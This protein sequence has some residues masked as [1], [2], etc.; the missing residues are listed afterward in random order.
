M[1]KIVSYRR[2]RHTQYTRQAIIVVD[3]IDSRE[4]AKELIGKEVSIK[5]SKAEIH[6]KITRLHGNKGRAV[7]LFEKGIP[8]QAIGMN[9]EIK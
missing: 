5:F 2:G 9:I 7:A 6:G 1:G 8:G 4:K 3:G